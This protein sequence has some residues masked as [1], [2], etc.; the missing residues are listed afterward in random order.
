MA[1]KK[2]APK[3]KTPPTRK[4]HRSAI[5]GR[6]VTK[7]YAEAHPKTTERETVPVRKPKKKKA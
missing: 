6:T 5:T 4:I 3:K 7:E 2:A 1:K